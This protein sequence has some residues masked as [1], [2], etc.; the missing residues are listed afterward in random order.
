[1]CCCSSVLGWIFPLMLY[2]HSGSRWPL[3]SSGSHC[4][5]S[6]WVQT[7]ACYEWMSWKYKIISVHME[8][9]ADFMFC[10]LPFIKTWYLNNRLYKWWFVGRSFE[11]TSLHFGRC[12]LVFLE[13]E[14]T[15]FWTEDSSLMIPD[16]RESTELAATVMLAIAS[17]ICNSQ[18]YDIN[19]NANVG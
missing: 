2:L 3:A 7:P 5:A 8:I 6:Y 10:Y 15:K 13:P 16:N 1:M 17:C 12:H 18:Y 14:V 19:Q 4:R 9:I 11:A